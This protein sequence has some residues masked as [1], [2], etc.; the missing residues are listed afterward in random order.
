MNL[1]FTTFACPNWR[2]NQIIDVAAQYGYHGIEFRCEAGHRHGVEITTAKS[3]RNRMR[4]QL[5]KAGITP[6]CLGLSL[7]LIEDDF[8][9]QLP[10]RLELAVDLG[11]PGLRVF[12]GRADESV[13]RQTH[14]ERGARALRAAADLAS[15]AGVEIWLETHDW[16]SRATDAAAIVRMADHE[17]AGINYD[18]MH[19]YRMGEPLD[20]TI[21]ELGTLVRHTHF[22]DGLAD[23]E[24]VVVRP[25]GEG[26]LPID[27]MFLALIQMG[28]D[29]YL[30][31]E[32]FY[33]QYGEDPDTALAAYHKDLIDLAQRHGVYIG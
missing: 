2:F 9:E 4:E 14:I 18:N 19:P 7:K 16:A 12:C 20:A 1:S 30:S 11:C 10:I 24:K 17:S 6:C 15:D 8:L 27:Q 28:F 5:E 3:Q 25:I 13:G 32:W 31:G 29:G 22:H 33:D 26:D 23:Q 21:A